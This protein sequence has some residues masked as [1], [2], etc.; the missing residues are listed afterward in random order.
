MKT[1]EDPILRLDQM[2]FFDDL[3]RSQLAAIARHI[4]WHEFDGGEVIFTP[5]RDLPSF[6]IVEEGKVRL[7][8][9]SEQGKEVTL[10]VVGPGGTFGETSAG[11]GRRQRAYAEALVPTSVCEVPKDAYLELVT[12]AP[13]LA[14]RTMDV[15]VE[16]L[17]WA[18][19]QIED[20]VFRSVPERVASL[21]LRL[22]QIHGRVGPTGVLIDLRLTHQEIGNMVGATRETVTNVLNAMRADGLIAVQHK[23]IRILDPKGLARLARQ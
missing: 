21:L 7:S 11:E 10:A 3:E 23:R 19:A 17:A 2:E 18:E 12:T 16:R 4:K 1:P 15:L 5:E 8:R 13:K 6:Y 22:S 14:A 9:A 20:L